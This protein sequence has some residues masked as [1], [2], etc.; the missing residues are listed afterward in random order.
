M[1]VTLDFE[2]HAKQEEVFYD[3]ARFKV[4]VAGRR[5]G[6]TTIAIFEIIKNAF[7]N[8]GSLSWFLS[9]TYTQ[10]KMIAWRMLLSYLDPDVIVKK[11]EM[12]LRLILEGGSEICLKGCDNEDSL[13]GV[14]VDFV[15]LDEYAQM[16]PTVW[17]EVIRPMLTDTK[18][19]AL[20]I[21]TPK[22]KNALWELWI[23]GQKQE[24]DFK[25]WRFSTRDNPFI[26]PHEIDIAKQELPARHFRQE[27]EAS[28]EDFKGLIYPE[29]NQDCIIKPIYLDKMFTYVGA[30]DPATTGT[31]GALKAIID[32]DGRVIIYEEYY[33]QDKRASEVAQTIK[34]DIQWFIDPASASKTIQREGKLYSVY[35]EYADYGIRARPAENDVDAGINRVGEYFKKGKIKIFNTCKNLIWELER[36]HWSEQNE[37]IGGQQK[38][39][40]YKMHD[41][42]VDS[43]RY[44]V[45][46]RTMTPSMEVPRKIPRGSVAAFLLEDELNANDWRNKYK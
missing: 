44:I 22:G 13:R 29:F 16:K 33:E 3:S 17:Y 11:Y 14:G 4:V 7:Q 34:E 45:M 35:D 15:V 41:H 2:L 25:S 21:G 31:T 23:K 6:K 37:S 36:Y 30:I 26:D 27:Y 9:P 24:N 19:S 38:P 8:K 42:L 46:S 18:G 10:S 40:P 20:F 5:F 12:E 28:F 32:G 39:K 43:L 1:E